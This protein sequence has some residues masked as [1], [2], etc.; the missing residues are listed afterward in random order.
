MDASELATVMLEW[1]ALQKQA[2]ALAERIKAAVLELGQTQTVGNVRASYSGG[3]KRYDYKGAVYNYEDQIGAL[4]EE[5][6]HEHIKLDYDYR[7][8]CNELVLGAIPFTESP[9]SVSLKV[10]K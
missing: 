5:F 7:A 3:R 10:L 8:M 9:P 4:P 1:E 6:W 2:D